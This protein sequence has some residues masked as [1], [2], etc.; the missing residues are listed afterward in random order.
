MSLWLGKR[1]Q[2]LHTLK[3]FPQKYV[4]MFVKKK[5]MIKQRKRTELLL[6]LC[7]GCIGVPYSCD[8][9]EVGNCIKIKI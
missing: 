8:F 3:W 4:C 5:R 7:K 2:K 1:M 9:S 6:S